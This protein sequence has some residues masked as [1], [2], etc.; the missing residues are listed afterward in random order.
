L[1]QSRSSLSEVASRLISPATILM[2]PVTIVRY[3]WDTGTTNSKILSSVHSD[4]LVNSCPALQSSQAQADTQVPLGPCIDSRSPFGPTNHS[5]ATFF[6]V[7]T[8]NERPFLLR[9]WRRRPAS[10][11]HSVQTTARAG[12]SVADKR[13]PARFSHRNQSGSSRPLPRLST[14]NETQHTSAPLLYL[15]G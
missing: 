10:L 12:T 14:C 13:Q 8:A 2:L 3:S 7:S 15:P 9:R 11:S 6:A 4:F 1:S 5:T